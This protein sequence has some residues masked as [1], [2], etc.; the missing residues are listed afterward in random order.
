MSETLFEIGKSG[1]KMTP[2]SGEDLQLELTGNFFIDTYRRLDD[3]I[4]SQ[5]KISLKERMTFFSLLSVTLDAGVPLTKALRTIAIEISNVRLKKIIQNLAKK[6]EGGR[7]LS[8]AM[9]DY[10]FIFTQSQIGMVNAG[11]MSG[12]LNEI[13]ERINEDVEKNTKLTSRIKGALLYPAIVIVIL[14][15]V[16]TLMMV[17]VIPKIGEVFK[18]SGKELPV[19]TQGLID[20]SGFLQANW[21]ILAGILVAIIIGLKVAIKTPLGRYYLHIFLL[22][23]PVVGNMMRMMCLAKFSRTLSALI[24]SGI[25]I[26]KALQIVADAVGNEVYKKRILIAS[27]DVS[28]G[29]PLGENMMGNEFLFPSIV[30]SMIAVGE[31]NAELA[32]VMDKVANYYESEVDVMSSNIS[33]L[34][35]PV[36]IVILG[37]SVGTLVMAIMQPLMS[38]TD[39]ADTL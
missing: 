6:I 14:G 2:T 38:L 15:I 12:K 1:E 16:I 29:I 24:T 18:Q 25:S 19:L 22:R 27:D 36:V 39:V 11:E 23:I 26:V 20:F 28:R 32:L 37:V 17:M 3:W 8:S 35:E 4:K 30:V 5:S 31:K 10:P 7:K 34:I 13:F 9:E 33:K 21:Y